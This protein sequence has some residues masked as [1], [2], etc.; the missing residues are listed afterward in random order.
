M[1]ALSR[2]SNTINEPLIVQDD[3]Q[4]GQNNVELQQN[5]VDEQTQLEN[6]ILTTEFEGNML[7][8]KSVILFVYV[9]KC[10][11]LFNLINE[12]VYVFQKLC[13]Y[14]CIVIDNLI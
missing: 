3:D 10:V 12:N 7:A 2:Y 8:I 4:Y 11:N 6:D 9:H 13:T 1:K 5:D 14:T